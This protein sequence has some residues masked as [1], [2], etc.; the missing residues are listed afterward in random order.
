[1]TTSSHPQEI[2]SSR[3]EAKERGCKRYYS[4]CKHHEGVQLRWASNGNCIKCTEEYFSKW[5]KGNTLKE[6]KDRKEWADRNPEKRLLQSARR[7]AKSK[8]IEFSLVPSDIVI[9]N[10]CP[11]LGITLD[12]KL[13]VY[14][15]PSIDRIDNTKGYT[16]DNIVIVPQLANR[17][18]NS[19]S[20]HGL[21]Q[22]N[23][24][25]SQRG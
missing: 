9:P 6:R 25:Y 20:I 23:N 19:L 22:L 13:G 14:N 10:T 12:S 7:N 1:M 17:C 8:G 11:A 21:N 4:T 3:K 5:R 16:P 2:A 24:F 15:R 18:K